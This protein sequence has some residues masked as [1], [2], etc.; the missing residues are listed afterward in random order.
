MPDPFLQKKLAPTQLRFILSQLLFFLQSSL[1]PSFPSSGDH[2]FRFGI[3]PKILAP[4]F[5][6]PAPNKVEYH[7][8]CQPELEL[9]KKRSNRI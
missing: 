4:L 5:N 9:E 3:G 6:Y 1:L 8:H 7:D 2:S